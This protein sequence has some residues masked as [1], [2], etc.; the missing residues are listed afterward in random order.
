MLVQVE[1]N[2]CPAKRFLHTFSLL[3]DSKMLGKQFLVKL[4][5]VPQGWTNQLLE[6]CQVLSMQRT[7][8][9]P[10]SH[11]SA[12]CEK[13]EGR[14]FGVKNQAVA[15]RDNSLECHKRNITF[16]DKDAHLQQFSTFHQRNAKRRKLGQSLTDGVIVKDG[17]YECQFCHKTFMERRRYYGHIGAHIRY[18][19]LSVDASPYD[20]AARTNND[21]SYLAVIPLAS[22]KMNIL[23]NKHETT[24]SVHS[25]KH[26]GSPQCISEA[27]TNGANHD[28]KLPEIPEAISSGFKV[29]IEHNNSAGAF[30]II[31]HASNENKIEC[32]PKEDAF[33]IT[34]AAFSENK[35]EYDPKEGGAEIAKVMSNSISVDRQIEDDDITRD[36][37][38]GSTK[39]EDFRSGLNDASQSCS[40][41]I[42][43][44][45]SRIESV[46]NQ[47]NDCEMTGDTSGIIEDNSVQD[48]KHNVCL[49]ARS[50]TLVEDAT[51]SKIIGKAG[52][53]SS[54]SKNVNDDNSDHTIGAY[55]SEKLAD[56]RN[57]TSIE[58]AEEITSKEKIVPAQFNCD[59]TD[60]KSDVME[61]TDAMNIQSNTCMDALTL[62]PSLINVDSTSYNTVDPSP[63]SMA[64]MIDDCN[65]HQ[66]VCEGHLFLSPSGNGPSYGVEAYSTDIFTSKAEEQVG[67]DTSNAEKGNT[68][69]DQTLTNKDIGIASTTS[70]ELSTSYIFTNIASEP[71]SG[72]ETN[73][74]CMFSGDLN[75]SLL[76]GIDTVDNELQ[77]YFRDSSIRNE[78]AAGDIMGSC[79]GRQALQFTVADQASSWV[80]SSDSLPILDMIPDQGQDE[81]RGTLPRNERANISGFEE[82]RLGSIEPSDFVIFTD[83]ASEPSEVATRSSMELFPDDQ[84]DWG[85][86][87]TK[88]V[89]ASVSTTVCVWCSREFSL[90]GIEPEPQSE[91]LGYMCPDCKAKISGQL[92]LL[93]NGFS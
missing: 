13:K 57:S 52:L 59:I 8:Q 46:Q 63:C 92:G 24:K 86:S 45:P 80:Q 60:Y 89:N 73:A 39:A 23:A 2:L 26:F 31:S 18:E 76:E 14:L 53:S 90:E 4:M 10:I 84:L 38:Q 17:K 32:S 49:D 12:E 72:I 66:K 47:I 67:W 58:I 62:A 21:S 20:T 48:G 9:T 77:D 3:M 15:E 54:K 44:E 7:A 70:N 78:E 79:H 36:Q 37:C 61:T 81:L 19:G 5:T 56:P 33:G 87:L 83:Q 88:M 64:S 30:G 69:S 85:M 82:L 93:N 22:S 28:P 16:G 29:E 6:V 71:T 55:K 68:G 40:P 34:E 41:V 75:E 50:P 42:T 27:D 11:V 25:Q 91:S 65:G 51:T 35:I 1:N 43:Q 74:E